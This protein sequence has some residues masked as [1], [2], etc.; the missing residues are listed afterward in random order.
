MSAL[1]AVACAFAGMYALWLHYLAVMALMRARDAGTLTPWA[2]RLGYPI[3]FVGY[4]LDFLVNVFV[5]SFL[6][7]E[8]PR[9]WLVTA[10]LSRHINGAPGYR[11]SFSAWVCSNL[12]DAYD[13]SGCHCK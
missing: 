10:R 4:G 1:Y 13:P 3:L 11:Q 9:E 12:L 7:L 2:R 8:V 6:L 5:L